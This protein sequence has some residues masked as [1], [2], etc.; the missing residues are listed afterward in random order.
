MATDKDEEIRE[1]RA[2]L[3]AMDAKSPPTPAPK[4]MSGCLIFVIVGVV[5]VGLVQLAT[6]GET[7]EKGEVASGP[8]EKT[9]EQMDRDRDY[10]RVYVTKEAIKRSLRDPDSARFGTVRV[11]RSGG[12][13]VVCGTVNA[14]N[15]F[16]GYTGERPFM[17]TE[18]RLTMPAEVT[19]AFQQA[20]RENCGPDPEPP[21]SG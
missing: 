7:V 17:A 14:R 3:D 5:L 4:K 20:W 18:E 8:T 2:R 11:Y 13:P 16:G 19:R 12:S 21:P 15:G 6:I 9:A 1:L 10:T